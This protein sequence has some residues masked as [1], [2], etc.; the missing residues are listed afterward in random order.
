MLPTLLSIGPFQITSFGVAVA[1]AFL[2]S[3]FIF[4]RKSREENYPE[5]DMFDGWLL[6][7]LWGLLWAR[8]G[9]IALHW[10]LFG[11]QPLR[12]IDFLTYPGLTIVFGLI[13]GLVYLYRFADQQRWDAFEVVDFA[14][15]A[16][17][18]GSVVLWIGAFFDGSS[19]GYPT[20][21]PWGV[22]FPV[23]FDKRHPVQLY[24]ALFYLLMFIYLAW[25]EPRY[26]TF[27]WY[28]D[29][30]HSAQTG[31]LTC[32]FF[33]GYGIIGVM[34]A[35][36]SPAQLTVYGISIDL[37]IKIAFFAYGFALLYVRSGRS[38]L[39]KK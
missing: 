7:L 26:R 39:P 17:T 11:L 34:L 16:L 36:L 21:L 35:L 3:S 2:A 31:F 18:L 25:V 8:I 30:K 29:K 13:A 19:F 6:S 14:V 38:F 23:V 9:F 32:L 20:N 33:M 22:Q 15:L 37:P 10:Q 24:A 28:R 4:W 1:I 27:A 12:W 5:D